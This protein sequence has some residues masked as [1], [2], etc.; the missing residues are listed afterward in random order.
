MIENGSFNRSQVSHLLAQQ[1]ENTLLFH[2]GY[3]EACGKLLLSKPR[4]SYSLGNSTN[5]IPHGNIVFS[6]NSGSYRFEPTFEGQEVV[7]YKI[8]KL[9]NKNSVHTITIIDNVKSDLERCGFSYCRRKS[10]DNWDEEPYIDE[11]NNTRTITLIGDFFENMRTGMY[12]PNQRLVK[13][14]AQQLTLDL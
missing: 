8:E 4:N 5:N 12:L 14:T 11:K 7:F 9:D 6:D 13:A 1:L 3:L 2:S 10:V